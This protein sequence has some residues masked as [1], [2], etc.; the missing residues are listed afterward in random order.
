MKRKKQ[1]GNDEGAP[2][3]SAPVVEA[4]E[5]VEA[6][7][8]VEASEASEDWSEPAVTTEVAR[9]ATFDAA[10]DGPTRAGEED[11]IADLPAES[12]RLEMTAGR[13]ASAEE[14]TSPVL[15]GDAAETSATAEGADAEAPLEVVAEQAEGEDSA[16]GVDS[17]K[18]LESIV[19]S[20]LFASDRALT[21]SD[22][23]RLLN[24]RDA[25]KLTAAL[26]ALRERHAETGIHLAS[27]AGGWQFRTSTENAPWVSKLIAGRPQ[28]LSRAMLETL[29]IVAYRQPVTRPEI[30]EIRGVDCGP[31]LKTLLER[32]LVRILGKK[33]EVGRPM[34]YGTTPEFLKTFSLRDLAELPTLREFHELSEQQKAVVDAKAPLPEGAPATTDADAAPRAEAGRS[35]FAP[36]PMD[37]AP[38]D[39]AEEEEL[40][41]ALENA[42]LAASRAAG[43]PPG[44]TV[45]AA[46]AGPEG[47]EA[48]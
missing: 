13:G 41:D 33:E 37:L 15:D 34:L 4:S 42:T 17:T 22:L 24:E 9:D 10:W 31:V 43:P 30:D 8:R 16:S 35:P 45:E 44:A 3:E 26:E 38:V 11:E 5:T 36:T 12:A 28:R 32:S 21:V 48:Q 6:F 46:A 23:K 47:Q 27:V 2:S 20:L 39:Q 25:K 18:R 1:K 40:L 14:V 19:E 29:A 7:E